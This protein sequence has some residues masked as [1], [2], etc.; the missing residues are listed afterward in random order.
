MYRVVAGAPNAAWTFQFSSCE[1]MAEKKSFEK[2]LQELEEIV[3]ELEAGEL[4]L[5][6]SIRKYETGV[7]L[8]SECYQYLEK[9]EKKI[10]RLVKKDDGTFGLEDMQN[11]T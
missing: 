1:I 11:E 6:D 10:Q 5:D 8:L 4:P 3:E 2:S 9:A 7:K